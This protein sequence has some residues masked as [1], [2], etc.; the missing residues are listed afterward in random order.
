MDYITWDSKLET[1]IDIIDEQHKRIVD[2]INNLMVAQKHG[3]RK[4]MAIVLSDVIDYTQSH[5]GFEEAMMEDA[6]Y[7]FLHAHQRVHQLFIKRIASF[8]ERYKAGEDVGEELHIMLSRCLITHIQK[9]DRHY[10]QSVKGKMIEAVSNQKKR[11][12]WLSRF[13]G[14][15]H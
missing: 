13:F 8:H 2:Y 5:F 3:D 12:G 15:G 4:A 9:E 7:E 1:G 14:G 6:G 11:A 10:V